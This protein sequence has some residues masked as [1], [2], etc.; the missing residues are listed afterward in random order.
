MLFTLS[1]PLLNSAFDLITVIFISG[2]IILSVL[3]LCFIFHLRFKSKSITHLQGFNSLWTV[4]FLLV[5]F[6]FLW[7]ITE[8]LR[9]P[10]FRRKYLYPFVPSF[11]IS[12]QAN[13]CK[14]HIVL[15]LGF[16]EPAFLVTLLF[17]LNASI[18]R[19]T[20]NNDKWA[21]TSVLLTCLPVATLQALL[22][23]FAP[24]K[25]RVPA[26]SSVVL[27]DGYGFETVLCAYPFLS[28][29]LFAV[30]GVAYSSWFL[31]SCWRVLLLV[32]NKGLR[33]RI[34]V[35]ASIVLV[36]IPLQIV[37]LGFS[38]LWSPHQ[39][40]YGVVSLVGFLAAFGCATA[41]E[42][43]LVIKP[44]SDALDAGGNCCV[45]TPQPGARQSEETEE[46][47]VVVRLEGG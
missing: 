9:L 33:V 18:K 36:A 1:L 27:N 12:Q 4:R 44:I 13:L 5:L 29:V 25:N 31:F 42:G 28:S 3:S 40:V 22:I 20:P 47:G 11:S 16:F 34:Y 46:S 21:I 24:F 17:L 32:I 14:V 19:K 23:F 30:F 2:L 35:L 15:S 7:S 38:V 10:F 39:E 37:S 26:E 41:G 43:I 8:L 45:S 6:I